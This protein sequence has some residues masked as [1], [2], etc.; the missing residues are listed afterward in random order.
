MKKKIYPI[1][2]ALAALTVFAFAETQS[3]GDMKMRLKASRDGSLYKM[4][5][6]AEFVLEVSNGGKP[7]GGIRFWS[8]V[9]KDG[10]IPVVSSH[11]ITDK[12]GRAVIK[13]GALNE[14]G[15]LRCAVGV[16]N[17]ETKKET[18]LL[19]GAGFELEK[20]RP[21]CPSPRI[22]P[23]TGKPKRECFRRSR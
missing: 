17:P 4:G 12:D 8:S 14:P 7:Q 21:G 1:L 2:A 5:E 16:Y 20:I 18:Q 22:S 3:D 11:G 15:V 10:A 9:S 19:A 6:P 13:A 23:N